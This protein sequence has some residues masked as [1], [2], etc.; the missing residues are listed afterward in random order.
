MKTT[1]ILFAI[2]FFS[3]ISCSK[4]DE[5]QASKLS[6]ASVHDGLSDVKIP[7]ASSPNNENSPGISQT[8]IIIKRF[9]VISDPTKVTFQLDLESNFIGAISIYIKEPSGQFFTLFKRLGTTSNN[10]FG[11]NS[12]FKSGEKLNFNASFTSVMPFLNLSDSEFVPTGNYSI[13]TGSSNWPSQ[14]QFIPL[15]TFLM[16]K[17]INGEWK[18]FINNYGVGNAAKLVNWKMI[19]DTGAL[20]Q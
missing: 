2:A 14:I 3:L 13:Q 18:I 17:E 12:N 15:N 5:S 16:N 19:I 7:D 4:D 10:L 11:D 20:K 1:K 8:S 9:G 6:E